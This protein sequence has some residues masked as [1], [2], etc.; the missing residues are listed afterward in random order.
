M[1]LLQ[2]IMSRVMIYENNLSR[3]I[4]FE[5]KAK[6]TEKMKISKN[7]GFIL[8]LTPLY[9]LQQEPPIIKGT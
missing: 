6:V 9:F 8:T 2:S 3:K 5:E 4:Q 7:H 1:Y